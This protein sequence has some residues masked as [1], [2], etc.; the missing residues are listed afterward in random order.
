M[1]NLGGKKIKHHDFRRMAAYIHPQIH[2]NGEKLI[3]KVSFV[4]ILDLT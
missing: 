2:I 3:G 4:S 1:L